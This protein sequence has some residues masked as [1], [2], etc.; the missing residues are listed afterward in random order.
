MKP[1]KLIVLILL[2]SSAFR[3]MAQKVDYKSGVLNVDGKDIA[4]I[5]KIKDKGSFGLTSTYEL[6]SIAGVKL[7]IV[8]LATDYTPDISR[9]QQKLLYAPAS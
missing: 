9:F 3:L 8:A 4:N 1:K 7:I 5:T 2:L 6:S